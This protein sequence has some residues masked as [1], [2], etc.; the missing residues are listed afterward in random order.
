MRRPLIRR[1][2]RGADRRARHFLYVSDTKVDM[3]YDQIPKPVLSR[4]AAEATV[5]LQVV[6][7]K[8]KEADNPGPVR[9]DKLAVV[10]RYVDSNYDVG[11]LDR[12]GAEGYFR[13]R[14][15]MRWGAVGE[16]I[17]SPMVL[18]LGRGGR[19][20]V[21]LGGALEHVIGSRHQPR[22]L[23]LPPSAFPALVDTLLG[24]AND[25]EG[26][27]VEGRASLA[28]DDFDLRSAEE[29]SLPGPAQPVEFLATAWADGEVTRDGDR[30]HVVLGSPWYVATASGAVPT[31]PAS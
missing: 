22:D 20:T 8:L 31:Q 13:G 23:A 28:S 25:P 4:I 27:V 26:R 30:R 3:L 16:N 5:N 24:T 18:F 10:E 17:G 7:V 21:A 1:F 2:R 29:F 15:R 6:S 9:A 11:S 19:D 14:M 12:I